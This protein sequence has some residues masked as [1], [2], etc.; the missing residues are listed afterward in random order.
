MEEALDKG[1]ATV[2]DMGMDREGVA[3]IFSDDGVGSCWCLE[4]CCTCCCCCCGCGHDQLF[5][6]RVV[7]QCMLLTFWWI[8]AYGSFE[9]DQPHRFRRDRYE[10]LAHRMRAPLVPE[11]RAVR[12][13]YSYD[14]SVPDAD[15]GEVVARVYANVAPPHKS[16]ILFF[17]G[18]G[19]VVGHPWSKAH[20]GFCLFLAE[21]GHVVVSVD[22]RR[23]P[24][25]PF[26]TS[27]RDAYAAVEWIHSSDAAAKLPAGCDAAANG[28]TL[29]GDSAG[30]NFA[31]VV[32]SLAR[33]GLDADLKPT[34]KAFNLRHLLLLYPA[35]FYVPGM[36]TARKHVTKYLLRKQIS[37]FFMS[38]YL[39]GS[40]DEREAMVRDRRCSPCL[41]GL[42]G[43]PSTTLVTASDDALLPSLEL[44]G[45]LMEASTSDAKRLHY[46]NTIH[47]F[48][49]LAV[50]SQSKNSRKDIVD[51]I[52]YLLA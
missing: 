1:A 21:S 36:E 10:K 38:S 24:E 31:L 26:P 6:I 12:G 39:Q 4:G 49:T 34:D 5:P 20:D 25:D 8:G 51:E 17:H 43:L 33:D 19:F 2:L 3:E 14:T 13:A 22:Y 35:V 7:N 37:S 32:A 50:H 18:G 16:I 46:D 11:A 9:A 48:A 28:L 23:A 27:V 52:A 41:A 45:E 40:I 30:G 44:F 42:D 47:G 15:G 29:S